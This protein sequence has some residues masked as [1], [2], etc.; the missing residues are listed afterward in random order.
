MLTIAL[1]LS[2]CGSSAPEAP[3]VN[4][5]VEA[6]APVADAHGEHGAAPIGA[7]E[8]L[9]GTDQRVFFVSPADG[10]SV[11]SPVHL[12]FGAEGIEIRAAGDL[13][14]NTGHHH[15]IVDGGPTELGL[16]VPKDDRNI[17]YGQ[18]QTEADL[19]LSPGPHTLTLQLADGAH[20]SYGASA[21]A[22]INIVVE[23]P[24]V[25]E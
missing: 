23:N 2:A 3:A 24:P 16:S 13:A 4:A 20:R 17:H 19:P 5:V 25:A 21:S 10:A 8:P 15:V 7:F 11:A 9:S 12:V 1:L 18:G 22:T 6:P 14:P